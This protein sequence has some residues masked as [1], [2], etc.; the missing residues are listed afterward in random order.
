MTPPIPAILNEHNLKNDHND[1]LRVRS[2]E[3]V[4]FAKCLHAFVSV[5]ASFQNKCHSLTFK[6]SVDT[7]KQLYNPMK[8]S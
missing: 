1:F 7:E 6:L 5:C 3:Q 4:F 2:N 8:I